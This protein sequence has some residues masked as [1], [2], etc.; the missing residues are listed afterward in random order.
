M[1]TLYVCCIESFGCALYITAHSEY[2]VMHRLEA[3]SPWYNYLCTLYGLS[4]FDS[5]T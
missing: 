3:T 5:F 1:Y 4:V 2:T